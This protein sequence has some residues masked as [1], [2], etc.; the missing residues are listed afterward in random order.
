MG[1]CGADADTIVAR[2]FLRAVAAGASAH[3]DHGRGVAE[4]FLATALGEAPDYD[5]KDTVKLSKLAHELGVEIKDRST[6]EIAIDVGEAPLSTPR[7]RNKCRHS[8]H[9]KN[10]R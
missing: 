5:F 9:R 10:N 6:R 2:N 3:S 4:V 1:V 7:H 8:S